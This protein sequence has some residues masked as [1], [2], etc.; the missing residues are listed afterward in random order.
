MMYHE[1][2]EAKI[3]QEI[4]CSLTKLVLNL[5]II[6]EKVRLLQIKISDA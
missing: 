2:T 3:Y 4:D 1:F 5:V 6:L